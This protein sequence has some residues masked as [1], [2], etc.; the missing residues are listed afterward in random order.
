MQNSCTTCHRDPKVE[1]NRGWI[2][3]SYCLLYWVSS[4]EMAVQS[5]KSRSEPVLQAKI[6]T[7]YPAV[8]M[9]MDRCGKMEMVEMI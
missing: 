9:D 7:S 5:L 6:R 8:T 2:Q 4:K 3:A 1:R